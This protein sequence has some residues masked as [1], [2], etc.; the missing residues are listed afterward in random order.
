MKR[1]IILSVNDNPE[2]LYYVPLAVWA[3]RQIGWEPVIFFDGFGTGIHSL[4]GNV[5]DKNDTKIMAYFLDSYAHLKRESD[6]R[7]DTI[8]QVSRLYAGHIQSIDP[9]DLLMTGDIDLIPLSDYW[10]PKADEITIYGYDLTDKRHFPICY[11]AMSKAEWIKI[12]QLSSNGTESD[13]KRDLDSMPQAK[14]T[15][16]YKYWFTDQDLIT[17]RIGNNTYRSILR[18]KIHNGLAQGRVDRGDWSMMHNGNFI[19]AHLHR[20]LYKAF[21][22]PEH[23][24][25]KLYQKKWREHMELLATVWPNEDWAWF[26][27][28]T[29]QF[30][31]LAK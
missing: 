8:T 11:I 3:W 19:D 22:N 6:Y 14:D 17:D 24:H 31:E 2:Y 25:F 4:I 21:Q 7:S 18:G 28:Y 5:L 23:E 13:I 12:M 26:I 27:E 20:D 9:A 1:H 15:D 30:A 29:K 16:F 10:H